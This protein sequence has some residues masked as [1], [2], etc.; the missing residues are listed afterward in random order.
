MN[1]FVS[2]LE[3]IYSDNFFYCSFYPSLNSIGF[4]HHFNSDSRFIKFDNRSDYLEGRRA[5]EAFGDFI[6]QRPSK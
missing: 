5:V 3:R 1:S 6:I 2:D 4:F